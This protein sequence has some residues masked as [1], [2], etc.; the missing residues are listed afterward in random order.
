MNCSVKIKGTVC[1]ISGDPQYKNGNARFKTVPGKHLYMI[2]N[3]FVCVFLVI[4]LCFSNLEFLLVVKPQMK[5]ISFPK[6]ED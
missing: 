1:V 5:I 3:V 2:K 4:L 6:Y